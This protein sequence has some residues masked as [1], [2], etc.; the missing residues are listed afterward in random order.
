LEGN[1]C[2]QNG[3]LHPKIVETQQSNK[4]DI[5]GGRYMRRE[6]HGSDM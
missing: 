3:L 2:S 1:I 5:D 6:Y 4:L